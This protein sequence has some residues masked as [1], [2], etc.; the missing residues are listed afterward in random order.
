MAQKKGTGKSP[1]RSVKMTK[2]PV[3]IEIVHEGDERFLIKIFPD[4]EVLREP[5]VK[6]PRKKRYPDRPYWTW[7][8][9]K[10]KKKGF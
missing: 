4:G 7:R 1:V 6:R 9:D 3:S 5:I 2:T 10:S 8:F